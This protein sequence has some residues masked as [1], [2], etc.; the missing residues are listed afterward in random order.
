MDTYA[1]L[2]ASILSLLVGMAL[3]W[4]VVV[5]RAEKKISALEKQN[6]DFAQERGQL[7]ERSYRI[8]DLSKALEQAESEKDAFTEE[9]AALKEALGSTRAELKAERDSAISL[10]ERLGK[11]EVDRNGFQDALNKIGNEKASLESRLDAEIKQSEEKIRLLQGARDQ[12]S[13]SFELLASRILE[14]KTKKFTDQN[15]ENLGALL[16]PLRE[17]IAEFQTKIETTYHSESKDRVALGEQVR[18][19]MQLNQSLSQDAKN[20]TSALR[21]SSKT[22]GTWGELVLERIM[23]ASGLRKG[24]EFVVQT[25]YMNESGGRAQPDV[26]VNLPEQRH[27]VIDSKVSLKAYEDF[28]DSEN[29]EE[30]KRVALGRHLDSI[31]VHMKSLS[32]KNYQDL[33]QLKTLDFVL[34]FVPIESAFMA[35][36]TSDRDLFMDG[37]NKNVLLVSPSTLLFVLRTVAHLWRQE[38]QN[39]NAQE[40]AK[41]GAELYDS[42]CGF[43][44]DLEDVGNRLNQAQESFNGAKNKLSSNRGNVIRRA[45]MLRDLGVKPN[46]RIPSGFSRD[47]NE[48]VDV[49]IE[50]VR[51]LLGDGVIGG[52]DVGEGQ[53]PMS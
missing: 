22:Q 41:R 2:G 21:G 43:L 51:Q 1:V 7:I 6:Y 11:A 8:S 4:L 31:R 26:T 12:L 17:K 33:Y 35:A 49:N 28:V 19:L 20:L 30:T 34:M 47:P 10:A 52:E 5:R 29:D 42:L 50:E 45:E 37:W 27:L 38:A 3:V 13:S 15:A 23:E 39:K 24:E 14:E 36:I 48:D 46:K 9:I 44:K 25:S 53:S 16:N 32:S 18:Q 40:I